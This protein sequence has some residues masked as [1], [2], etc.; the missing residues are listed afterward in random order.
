MNS[1]VENKEELHAR[2]A[3]DNYWMALRTVW[4]EEVG[5][6]R[7]GTVGGRRDTSSRGQYRELRDT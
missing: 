2:R 1:S 6:E 5:K 7:I 3:R 4:R